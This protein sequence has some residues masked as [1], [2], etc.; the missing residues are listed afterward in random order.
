MP[1]RY[2][3]CQSLITKLEIEN[4]ELKEQLTEAEEVTHW[5]QAVLTALNVGDVQKDSLLHEKLRKVMIGYRKKY[6]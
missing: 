4:A 5:A 2:A 6:L 3:D 1:F